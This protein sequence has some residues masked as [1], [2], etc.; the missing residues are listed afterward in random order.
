MELPSTLKTIY[1]WVILGPMGPNLPL[2]L[3]NK[4]QMGVDGGAH[5]SNNLL[6]WVGDADSLS[7]AINAGVV[8]KFPTEKDESD[9][10]LALSLFK[11]SKGYFFHLWGFLGGRK[12]H[13]LF[14]IGEGLHFLDQHPQSQL[15]FYNN[16]GLISFMLF[17]AGLWEFYHQGIFSLG[18]L[19]KTSVKMTGDC[20]YPLNSS[21]TLKPL[22]S[23]GLS[24]V[25]SGKITVETEGP[26][27]IYFPEG[28]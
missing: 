26:L 22:S 2:N 9:F 25:A 28:K 21:S 8:F 11:E 5:F 10:A 20:R 17:G 12:D 4:A 14:N 15:H 27:F 24:N 3:R 19:K 1:E 23:Q 16:Q 7:F 18:S 13:E 6:A